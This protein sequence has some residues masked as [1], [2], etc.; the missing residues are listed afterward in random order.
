M[1]IDQFGR[2]IPEGRPSPPRSGAQI[3]A[4]PNDRESYD[5]S[6]R[7]TPRELDRM[8]TA[9][10][11]GDITDQCRL[12]RE[13]PEKN[14][15]IRHALGTRRNALS[16]C[17]FSIAP[18]A[19]NDPVAEAVAAELTRQLEE[20]GG[21]YPGVG[22]LASFA[23]LLR[24]LSDAVLPG[25]A[26]AET[27]WR[28]GG[29][30]FFGW[31]SVEQQF[32]TFQDSFSPRL[33]T[34]GRYD[35]VELP[36]GK[37]VFHETAE[38]GV[39]TARGGLIRPLA[40]LHCFANITTKDLLSFIERYGMPFIVARC[41]SNTFATE[42]DKIK[43]MILNFGPDGGGVF[44]KA[45][46]FE[47]LQAAS[48]GGEVYFKLLQYVDAAI[49]KVLLGQT[50][51]SGESSGLSKGDSQSAVR[52]DILEADARALEET[53]RNDLFRPWMQYNYGPGVPVPTLAIE[54][55]QPEDSAN[56]ATTVKTLHEAGYETDPVEVSRRVGFAVKRPAAD[57]PPTP[58]P[59]PGAA[60]P[61]PAGAGDEARFRAAKLKCEAIGIAIR[62][63]I[64]T[65]E[66]GLEAMIRGELGLPEMQEVVRSAWDASGGIRQPITLKL[67]TASDAEAAPGSQSGVE[68]AEPG[69]PDALEAWL[70]P[71]AGEIAALAECDDDAEFGERL[72]A[73]ASG[74]SIKLEQSKDFENALGELILSAIRAGSMS[75]LR[76]GARR[77]GG[78]E[79]REPK[80]VAG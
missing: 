26:A 45:V 73:L 64:L 29:A 33:R 43:Q 22:R 25:F 24:N 32:F 69:P 27:V 6:R 28:P 57:S 47:L 68:L 11:T 59:A 70:G 66:A 30:G 51:S 39:D 13:L 8:M 50:A 19:K 34:N 76:R 5:V 10:N 2:P 72:A 16:G 42:S 56:L 77:K 60:D 63:G 44:S 35:G 17:L 21:A 20:A 62:A 14:Y 48:N 55:S 53:I 4:N 18:G 52:Q 37:I 61:P 74:S 12:S 7:L 78:N 38:N 54:T 41:D 67:P 49:E 1:I 36:Y 58:E 71:I 79:L 46:E 31:R 23:R 80:S 75:S 15:T 3:F 65:P 40:W 9:A